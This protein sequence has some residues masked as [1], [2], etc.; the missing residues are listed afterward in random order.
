MKNTIMYF[1]DLDPNDIHQTGKTYRFVVDGLTYLF[2]PIQ[3]SLKEIEELEE[4]RKVLAYSSIRLHE[5]VLNKQQKRVTSF[6]N[7]NYVLLKLID[8]W[9]QPIGFIDILYFRDLN[10]QVDSYQSLLRNN[11]HKLWSN[12]IDYFAYQVNQFGKKHPIIRESFSYFC[13]L[14]ENAIQYTMMISKEAPLGLSHH[15]IKE[16][17]RKLDLY[18]PLNIV[19]D[20]KVR[21][22]AEYFKDQFFHHYLP[23]EEIEYVL[24]YVLKEEEY[25][26]FYTRM[27]FPSFYFDIYE[28]ILSHQEEEKE[29]LCI[30]HKTEQYEELLKQI[31]THISKKVRFLKPDWL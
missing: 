3:R 28:E 29:L 19:V 22:L 5:I 21:D 7:E 30:I 9:K 16:N 10:V 24:N 27:L 18:N 17:M 1:Y 23:F 13:G 20:Y 15:R 25:I 4:I 31:Y 6:Q 11:W 26:P 8:D 14:A 2:L 12:K